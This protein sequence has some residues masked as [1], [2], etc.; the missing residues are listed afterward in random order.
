MSADIWTALIY[1]AL[2]GSGK[3]VTGRPVTTASPHDDM[4][5]TS[6]SVETSTQPLKLKNQEPSDSMLEKHPVPTQMP[7]LQQPLFK[8]KC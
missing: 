7:L 3:G 4:D 1:K 6:R 2:R 5:T 8:S